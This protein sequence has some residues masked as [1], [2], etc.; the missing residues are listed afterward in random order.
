MDAG[1]CRPH[2]DYPCCWT[3][4]VIGRGRE[5]LQRAIAEVIGESGHTVSFSRS[6]AGGIYHCL[7]LTVTVAS[8]AARL[9]LY[10]RLCAHPSI[11]VV[12]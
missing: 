8:E 12:M 7:N 3:Y 5:E 9:D 11:R 6:S 2:I 4:K 1:G 10:R